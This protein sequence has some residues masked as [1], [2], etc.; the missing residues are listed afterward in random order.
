[1][2]VGLSSKAR[3]V[4][5]STNGSG[6]APASRDPF[7]ARL[8]V[9]HVPGD[10]LPDPLRQRIRAGLKARSRAPIALHHLI[11]VPRSDGGREVFAL[12]EYS[13]YEDCMARWPDHKAGLQH[14][15]GELATVFDGDLG[16]TKEEE[17]ARHGEKY[18]HKQI[19][20]NQDCVAVGA[21]RAVFDPPGA[22]SAAEPGGSLAL[23]SLA[24]RDLRC[25][26]RSYNRVLVADVD[27][28]SQLEMYVDV[29]SAR[30]QIGEIRGPRADTVSAK[31]FN[32][33]RHVY[34]LSGADVSRVEL[35]ID[36]G[37]HILPVDLP[38]EELI[39]LRDLDGDGHL[40]VL[41]S[42]LCFKPPQMAGFWGGPCDTEPREKVAYAYDAEKDIYKPG[43]EGRVV[44]RRLHDR[45]M[46]SLAA[47]QSGDAAQTWREAAEIDPTW[48]W[49]PYN[50]ACLA[51]V[52][53]RRDD[54]IA[55]IQLLADRT[56]DLDLLHRLDTD[57]DLT[58]VRE[59]PAFQDA[60]GA[61]ARAALEGYH[62]ARPADAEDT[63]CAGLQFFDFGS[64]S[65][66]YSYTCAGCCE[67]SGAFSYAQGRLQ[68]EIRSLKPKDGASSGSDVPLEIKAIYKLTLSGKQVCF[69]RVEA[70]GL[71][72]DLPHEPLP[73]GCWDN[74]EQ[75][76]Q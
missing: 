43:V 5:F 72:E 4:G 20:L 67:F 27:G 35:S 14:C 10:T 28:D 61:V 13:V 7:A 66:G 58:S 57:P 42:K 31:L 73:D 22:G 56:P 74:R 52:Q 38:A 19:R 9:V 23:T 24:L 41:R 15:Q 17:E 50:L 48:S 55:Q 46:K 26:P 18:R 33:D 69:D 70:T 62:F 59:L 12:Y 3:V 47:K 32:S 53:G 34:I 45:A 8:R 1:M 39:E 29:T 11:D 36:L 71:S 2:S 25:L 75:P 21:V 51:A 40:D 68:L 6:A 60:V 54:A 44:A 65:T 49:P 37:D 64:G 16:L 63:V 76:A 30:E